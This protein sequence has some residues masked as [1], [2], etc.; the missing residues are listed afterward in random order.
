MNSELSKERTLE[1]ARA[2]SLRLLARR[3][4]GGEELRQRLMAAQFPPA[5]AK[6]VVDVLSAEGYQSD[7]RF[8]RALTRRRVG[9][10][11]GPL[12]LRAELR[13][14][15]IEDL[16]GLLLSAEECGEVMANAHDKRFGKEPPVSPEEW[17]RRERFLI[18]RGFSRSEV[19]AFLRRLGSAGARP[20]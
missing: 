14:R 1:Q 19:I 6:R 18:R 10:G 17:S 16:D 8:V 20:T 11:Y 2:F 9:Q 3:E 5:I 4:Y 7:H 13:Q 12:R 15:G